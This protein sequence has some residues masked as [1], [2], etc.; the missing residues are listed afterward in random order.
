M[1]ARKGALEGEVRKVT[2]DLQLVYQQAVSFL[3]MAL[4]S[5]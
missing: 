5:I 2:S 3:K 4:K 1:G